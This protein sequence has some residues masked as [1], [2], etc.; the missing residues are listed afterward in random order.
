M[1]EVIDA[2]FEKKVKLSV[3]VVNNFFDLLNLTIILHFRACYCC[4]EAD[5]DGTSDVI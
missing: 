5:K 1:Q 2:M 3:S 4:A